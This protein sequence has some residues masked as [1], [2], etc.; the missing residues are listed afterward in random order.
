[1]SN[2]KWAKNQHSEPV[3][4]VPRSRLYD[5]IRNRRREKWRGTNIR[6][7]KQ[8]RGCFWMKEKEGKRGQ[9]VTS[10]VTDNESAMI[11]TSAG[12]IQGYIGIAV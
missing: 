2:E 8:G 11:H 6:M 9:E 4:K 5:I 12:Y 7:R 3:E 1:M 10:N